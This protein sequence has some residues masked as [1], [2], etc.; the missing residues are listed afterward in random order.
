MISFTIDKFS[1]WPLKD[2]VSLYVQEIGGYFEI[3]KYTIEFFVP[4]EYRDF[5]LIK[6]PLLEEVRYIL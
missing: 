2:D 1:K 6:Y 4:V 3:Q 5:I